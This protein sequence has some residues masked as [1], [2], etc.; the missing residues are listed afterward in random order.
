MAT[1]AKLMVSRERK[2]WVVP[3]EV[4]MSIYLTRSLACKAFATPHRATLTWD[5]PARCENCGKPATGRYG[6]EM[7][8][9]CGKCVKAARKLD[10]MPAPV[11]V[12]GKRYVAV[13]EK[14]AGTC[15]GCAAPVGHALCTAIHRATRDGICTGNRIIWQEQPKAKKAKR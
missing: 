9:L 7:V 2:V 11:I 13:P 3:H 5:E 15:Y 14:R 1:R 12:K 8:A 4:G 6:D 10:G